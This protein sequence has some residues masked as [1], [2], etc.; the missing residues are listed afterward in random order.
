MQPDLRR[1][2]IGEMRLA[3][4]AEVQNDPELAFKHLERAHIL[5]QR[6]LIP[7]ITT[8]W[9]M[10]RLARRR[11]DGVETRG[12]VVRLLAVFPGY[13]FGWIPKGNTGGANVSAMAPMTIPSDLAPLLANYSVWR[14]VAVRV[15]AWSVLAVTAIMAM[16]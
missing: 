11:Q 15:A 2:F 3:D 5:G 16:R 7:H 13:A 14:D 10:L 4:I 6:Y 8:H 1:A 12:Q 9:H